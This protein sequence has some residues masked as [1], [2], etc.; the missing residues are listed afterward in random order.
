MTGNIIYQR[1]LAARFD[2]LLSMIKAKQTPR[3]SQF[4]IM[5]ELGP[6]MEIGIKGFILVKRQEIQRSHYVY[7]QEEKL[8][9]A[10]VESA[11]VDPVPPPQEGC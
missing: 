5:M 11:D 8:E 10:H 9:L 6:G 3:R 4:N 1:M 7:A 2:A